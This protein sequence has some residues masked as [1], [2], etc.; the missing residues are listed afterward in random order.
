MGLTVSGLVCEDLPTLL[1]GSNFTLWSEDQHC[2]SL[3][4]SYALRTKKNSKNDL[5]TY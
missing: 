5:G 3:K 4:Y 1:R 2:G